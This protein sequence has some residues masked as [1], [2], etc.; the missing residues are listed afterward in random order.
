[1]GGSPQPKLWAIRQAEEVWF[2]TILCRCFSRSAT[3]STPWGWTYQV[4]ASQQLLG[5]FQ[6]LTQ[7]TRALPVPLLTSAVNFLGLGARAIGSSVTAAIHAVTG[8]LLHTEQTCHGGLENDMHLV[9][10]CGCNDSC[11][12]REGGAQASLGYAD[13]LL[14]QHSQQ[15]LRMAC[16]HPAEWCSAANACSLG[17]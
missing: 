11:P 15:G 1:M 3:S 8:C 9:R 4:K 16:S 14:F 6:V 17:S 5:Q 2:Q 12:G 13:R 7:R 10:I